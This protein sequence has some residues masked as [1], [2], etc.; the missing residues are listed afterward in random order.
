MTDFE[1]HLRASKYI[2]LGGCGTKVFCYFGIFAALRDHLPE[3]QRWHDNMQGIC[4]VSSGSVA[5]LLLLMNADAKRVIETTEDSMT[6]ENLATY[7]IAGVFSR[8][9]LD[10]GESLRA[11]IDRAI[12]TCGLSPHITFATLHSITHK[13]FIVQAANLNEMRSMN[14]S[15]ET[16][17]D[18]CIRDAIYYSMTVPFIFEPGR[19]KND[20]MIDGCALD[21]CPTDVFPFDETM[22]VFVHLDQTQPQ[23]RDISDLKSFA[24]AIMGC[25]S[26]NIGRRV[27][28]EARRSPHRFIRVQP[29]AEHDNLL[30]MD[31]QRGNSLMRLGYVSLLL[32]LRPELASTIYKLLRLRL[33]PAAKLP[34]PTAGESSYAL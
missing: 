8:Y 7:D 6:I 12:E 34:S 28:E 26:R 23:R 30:S 15:H 5:A 4:G 21:L 18:V 20:V 3:F 11:I 24:H 14:F 25:C 32:R 31:P 33:G 17:P 27:L 10:S 2:V 1:T 9:G 19:H 13:A 29:S 22:H 16:T